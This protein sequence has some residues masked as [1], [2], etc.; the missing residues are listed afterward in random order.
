MHTALNSSTLLQH[1][2][3]YEASALKH[4]PDSGVDA[5]N[6]WDGLAF[7]LDQHQL[8]V[9]V[10]VID[11]IIPPPRLTPV[12]GSVDWLLGLTNVRGSLITVVDLRLFL[13]PERTP[14][15][16]KSQV[17]I[18]SVENQNIGL[19][20]DE[21]LGQRHFATDAAEEIDVE[22]WQDIH[23]YISKSYR[24]NDSDWGILNLMGL[25]HDRRFLDGAA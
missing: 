15:T 24:Q 4:Q 2:L 19:L 14:I 13:R 8:C 21:I 22:Q 23:Q 17:L 16:S 20:V 25:L 7:R 3:D 11:E 9:D 1:L 6:R 10:V 12:P 5:A 18:T